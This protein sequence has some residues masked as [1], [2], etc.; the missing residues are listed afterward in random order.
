MS[1]IAVVDDNSLN[2][3][4]AVD[5]LK[6]DYEVY[7]LLSGEELLNFL[8]HIIPD[9]ILLDIVMP[10]MNGFEVLQ[11]IK[12][13]PVWRNI[14]VIF[15]TSEMSEEK[16]VLGLGQGAVDYIKKPFVPEIMRYRIKIHLE[17]EQHRKKM[18]NIIKEKTRMI[19][20]LQNAIIISCFDL[21][22]CRDGQTGG[23]AERTSFYVK[24]LADSMLKQDIY[25]EELYNIGV[26]DLVRAALL[27]DIGKIG[28]KDHTLLKP[29]TLDNGEFEYMKQHT[30]LGYHTLLKAAASIGGVVS[31]L[32]T[33]MK[34]A[35]Y[36]HERW[37]GTGY[38][39]GLKG[40]EIPLEARIT[41][42][43]DVYDAL[44]SKRTYKKNFSHEEAV[45]IIKKESGKQFDP[46]LVKAF[47]N[48]EHEFY[49][50]CFERE[51]N[52]LQAKSLF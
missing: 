36:H 49:L 17:L 33:A 16:E 26:A 1:K 44:T 46:E 3:K 37:D 8:T 12:K 13:D 34:V 10:Q 21:L 39:R 4:R 35:C 23:H 48:C 45:G 5:T 31:T 38:L 30:V 41:A 29:A 27:H 25:T 47:L 24:I 43:A 20:A 7:P 11:K 28:I 19:N 52:N 2:L 32:E 9:L 6:F 40:T 14:P 15:L 22:E 42:I 50:Y 51:I 18:E